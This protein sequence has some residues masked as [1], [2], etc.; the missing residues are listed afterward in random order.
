MSPPKALVGGP[1]TSELGSRQKHSGTTQEELKAE[2]TKLIKYFL[3]SM[4]IPEK[5]LWVN[6]SP[7][8]KDRIIPQSFGLTEMGRDLLAQDYMLKQITASLIY[9]EDETG[10]KFWKRIYAESAKRY[11]T[12]NI[13]VNT[14]NKVWIVP[15]K[16]VVYEN[17]KAGTAYVVESKLKVMLEQDYLSLEK[18]NSPP[19]Q[20]E[21]ISALGSQIV[22]EIVIPELTK[23][24]NEGKNFAQ[25][26]QVYNSLILATWYKK[27]IKDSILAQV[28]ADKNKVEGIGYKTDSPPLVGG[29]RG[30]GLDGISPHPN[31]PHKGGGNSDVESIYQRYLQAFK[32]GVYNY[33]KE[34]SDPITKETTARKYFSGGVILGGLLSSSAMNAT[35][36]NAGDVLRFVQ[37]DV[38]IKDSRAMVVVEA[39]AK[40]Q[41]KDSAMA[42]PIHLYEVQQELDFV[43]VKDYSHGEV[44]K[45]V[46]K[47]FEY[48]QGLENLASEK[49]LES[50]DDVSKREDII[51]TQQDLWSVL[52]QMEGATKQQIF[53]SVDIGEFNQ[54]NLNRFILIQL[55]RY[56]AQF[57]V[58]A[59]SYM[60]TIES[61]NKENLLIVHALDLYEVNSVR[62]PLLKMLWGE[63]L[64]AKVVTI[65]K[66]ISIDK[67][68]FKNFIELPKAQA[69]YGCIIQLKDYKKGYLARW[70]NAVDIAKT[71]PAR[72]K[73]IKQMLPL[74]SI[75][76]QMPLDMFWA[77]LVLRIGEYAALRTAQDVDQNIVRK[78]ES[79]EGQHLKSIREHKLEITMPQDREDDK[80]Y[81]KEMFKWSILE[82]VQT[83][84]AELI[85]GDPLHPLLDMNEEIRQP[86]KNPDNYYQLR[87][88]YVF[89]RMVEI[90]E[91]D[92]RKYGFQTIVPGR[93]RAQ[94]QAQMYLLTDKDK[95]GLLKE[96]MLEV[97]RIAR[98]ETDIVEKSRKDMREFTDQAMIFQDPV[99]EA[100]SSQ[101]SVYARNQWARSRGA[102]LSQ[103]FR[104][105]FNKFMTDREYRQEVRRKVVEGFDYNQAK[106]WYRAKMASRMT[107]PKGFW[108]NEITARNYSLVVL[109]D[110]E[111]GKFKTARE[112]S[113]V[114]TMVEL[115][116]NNVMNHVS[117]LDSTKYPNGQLGFLRE[118]GLGSFLAKKMEDM[119]ASP[120]KWLWDV[121]PEVAAAIHPSEIQDSY[122]TDSENARMAILEVLNT[123]DGFREARLQGNVELMADIYRK[124]VIEKYGQV[125]FFG[126]AHGLSG[127][128]TGYRN[129][130]DKQ[131]S[132]AAMLRFA[133]PELVDQK[134]PKALRTLE[135]E[136]N[137]WT[138]PENARVEI[139]KALD[140][141]QDEGEFPEAEKQGHSFKAAREAENFKA[142]AD[143]YRRHVIGYRAKN[144][145]RYQNG[146]YGFFM[147]VGNLSGIMM[148]EKEYL[149]YEKT[150]LALVR[151]VLPKLVNHP[152]G[153][154]LSDFSRGNKG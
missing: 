87:A 122:W 70:K 33:I 44:G 111:G 13:P 21:G 11:G 151:F 36:M 46:R 37:G 119:G 56:L 138:N 117:T 154:R 79:H 123:I 48:F 92:T 120:A 106:W 49:V 94:I 73:D 32:K 61:A 67:K 1:G 2:A 140:S 116:R 129:Y 55:P 126:E 59:Q 53:G 86:V 5:D 63:P 131:S 113:D 26:R 97:G 43:P 58:Y 74:V 124:E 135:I 10:K 130:F 118:K 72:M 150:P 144:R 148:R 28:Y 60:G 93:V 76:R 75:G 23:E 16:A 51:K 108:D 81:N 38:D 89:N 99:Q 143:L 146:Q 105:L 35:K 45:V 152:D 8:E 96:V 85:H 57:G 139:L 88:C 115:Y 127:L 17:A 34:E 110:I 77:N 50:K 65:D 83:I 30:G 84:I 19:H 136:D 109:D 25:L 22:R 64:T 114:K 149:N 66:P 18:H 41:N 102:F 141:I 6:L 80:P 3:A 14:F 91:R 9:P 95:R 90:I 40:P 15:E 133:V 24:V 54:G 98:N 137:Y 134:N 68:V 112:A 47:L 147:E 128:M 29:V 125:I 103:R 31:P 82:E 12:T 39:F 52:S 78:V 27:K 42:T 142:M 62:A 4:T 153:L 132:P 104:G 145:A 69:N 71:V 121:L 101:E 100:G 20:G 7:Y 107:F